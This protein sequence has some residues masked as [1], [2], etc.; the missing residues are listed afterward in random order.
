MASWPVAVAS[1]APDVTIRRH[2]ARAPAPILKGVHRAGSAFVFWMQDFYSL[3][4]A[5][6]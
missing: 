5:R 3:A 1:L 2:A 4:A 6:F